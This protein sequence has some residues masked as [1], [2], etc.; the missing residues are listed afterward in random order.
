M[1]RSYENTNYQSTFPHKEEKDIVA[2]LQL[3]LRPALKKLLTYLEGHLEDY[4]SSCRDLSIY[5]GLSGILLLGL[6]LKQ[7]PDLVSALQL[8]DFVTRAQS[9]VVETVHNREKSKLFKNVSVLTSDYVGPCLVGALFHREQI[10][11]PAIK[12]A[13]SACFDKIVRCERYAT[14]PSSSDMPNELLYGRAGYLACLLLLLDAGYDVPVNC[15]STVVEQILCEGRRLSKEMQSNG[16]YQDLIKPWA[17]RCPPLMFQWHGKAY[18][19]AAHGFAGILM[20]LLKIHQQMP[21]ALPDAA[22][23]DLILPTVT[24]LSELHFDGEEHYNWPSSLGNSNDRLVQWCHGAPGII[25]LLLLAH[26]ITSDASYLEKA[27]KGGREVWKRGLLRKGCGLCHGS[28]GN[29]YALLSLYQHTHKSEYLQQAAV[30]AEWC[31]DYFNNAERTPDRP[32]SLFEGISGAIWFLLD[33]LE[34]VSGK[35]PILH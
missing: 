18:L 13:C 20:T 16:T 8:E 26:K 30:F 3:F 4:R 31:T 33:M 5:T 32:L 24:W 21:Q 29:G 1:S 2:D 27:E 15:I 35:F 17:L 6:R 10:A 9:L 12:K 22:L 14:A 19:G 34:P 25:P 11:E 7:S 28:A 23:D